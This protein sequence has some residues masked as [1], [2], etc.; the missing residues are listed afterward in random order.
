MTIL[1]TILVLYLF[2]RTG[3]YIISEAMKIERQKEFKKNLDNFDGK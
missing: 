1:I 2:Y 3:K